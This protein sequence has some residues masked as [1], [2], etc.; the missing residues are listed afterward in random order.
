MFS[1][2]IDCFWISIR[3]TCVEDWSKIEGE[4]MKSNFSALVNL[5]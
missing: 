5:I 4:E 2:S 3:F 1:R